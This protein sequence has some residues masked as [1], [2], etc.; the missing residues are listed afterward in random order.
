MRTPRTNI[1]D[2]RPQKF[3]ILESVEGISQAVDENNLSYKYS[4]DAM[5]VEVTNGVIVTGHGY[6]KHIAK[7]AP[8]PIVSFFY[9]AYSSGG[10]DIIYVIAAAEDDIYYWDELSEEW[11]SI[12]G[13]ETIT[14]GDFDFVNYQEEDT[15]MVIFTNGID[16]VFKW[17]GPGDGEE[18]NT[19]EKLYYVS[20]EDQAPRGR[21]ITLHYERLWIGY[22]PDDPQTVYFSDDMNPSDWEVAAE[23]GGAINFTTWDGGRVKCVENL[24]DDIVV[25]KQNSLWAIRGT[26]PGEY[27]KTQIFA[28]DGILAPYSI[29]KSYNKAFF[30]AGQ[31]IMQYNGMVAEPLEPYRLRYFYN[32]LNQAALDQ[33]YGIVHKNVLY[34][35]VPV[36][37]SM[38]NNRVIEY[39][40]FRRSIMIRDIPVDTFMEIDG[41]LLFTKPGGTYI[42]AY[43]KG[44]DYD[45]DPIS[46]YWNIPCKDFSYPNAKKEPSEIY[47]DA[48]GGTEDEPASLKVTAIVDG[49]TEKSKTITLPVN[50][51]NKRLQLRSSGRS[52]GYKIENVDGGVVNV[53][54]FTV[55]LDVD[56]D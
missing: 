56:E 8:K 51:R 29:C 28:A 49:Q 54:G 42:Y 38:T 11:V 40:I 46:M 37:S 45:G 36:G 5:N 6:G 30:M 23:G 52:I 44:Y 4:S 48:W 39:D 25:L 24:F 20:A 22:C 35:A 31:G 15:T 14:T 53:A 43:G 7:P 26:Y 32:S 12:K 13:E 9:F 27:S 3:N 55:I 33:A 41:Q 34:M 47:I 19:I 16:E 50:R 18:V 1:K 17:T 10:I 21:C 2:E